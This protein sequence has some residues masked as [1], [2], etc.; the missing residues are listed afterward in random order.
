M[1]LRGS[2]PD[3]ARSGPPWRGK[4]F[5]L[6]FRHEGLRWEGGAALSCTDRRKVKGGVW[7]AVKLR[8]W[9]DGAQSGHQ[10]RLRP[11]RPRA[12]APPV[13]HYGTLFPHF[14]F[15]PPL[16]IHSIAP[17]PCEEGTVLIPQ[18]G[19]K[20]KGGYILF[21]TLLHVSEEG[22]II[23]ARAR[24]P[25]GGRLRFK[26]RGSGIFRTPRG[27]RDVLKRRGAYSN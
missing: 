18:R 11:R 3:Y 16:C 23:A 4:L 26:T 12:P 2:V 5:R 8:N 22:P 20:K 9:E 24:T 13:K 7:S 10:S 27:L 25:A 17:S 19:D 15:F 14:L 21:S 1:C 6:A